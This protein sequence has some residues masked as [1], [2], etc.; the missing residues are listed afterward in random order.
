MTVRHA[1]VT[2]VELMVALTMISIVMTLGIPS[3]QQIMRANR[4]IA[5][6]NSLL[7]SLYLSRSHAIKQN[8]RVTVCKSANGS[9]CAAAGGWEQ[10]WI[11]FT[12][13]DNDAAYDGA[14]EDLIAVQNEPLSGLVMVGDTSVSNYVSYVPRGNTESIDGDIQAGEITTCSETGSHLGRSLRISPTGRLEV[15]DRVDCT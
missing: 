11:A 1:G 4:M 9:E 6:N 8:V 7:G 3:F 13:L 2:L 10:G 12:D 14:G 15:R 5:V